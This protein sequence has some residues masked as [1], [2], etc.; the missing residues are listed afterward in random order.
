MGSRLIVE[1]NISDEVL[2]V[3]VPKCCIQPIIE[4]SIKHGISGERN[5]IRIKL[6]AMIHDGQFVIR[7]SDNGIGMPPETLAGLKAS[8]ADTSF[9]SRQESI[10]LANLYSRL[11]IMYGDD[12]GIDIKSTAGEGTTVILILCSQEDKNASSVD[13]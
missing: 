7:V 9:G 12:A 5:S 1:K 8:F 13:C 4:N 3:E 11:K 10:G 6:S 2:D